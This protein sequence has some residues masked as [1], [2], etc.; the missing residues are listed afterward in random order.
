M[1]SGYIDAFGKIDTPFYFY[2]MDLFRT[3]VSE[4]ASLSSQYGIK[5]HYAI[6]ANTEERLLRHIASY[7]FGADCVSG[8]EVL[9][10][11]RCGFRP[12]DIVFAGVGKSDREITESLKLGIGTFN[13]ESLQEIEV[14][15]GFAASLGVRA[16]VS[17]RINP[18]ID[19]HTHKYVTTGLYENKFG[20]SRHE[21]EAL[22]ALLGRCGAVDLQGLHFHIGSQITDVEEVY[23]L[24]CRR[25]SEIVR[26]FEDKGF[27]IRNIDLGGGP[28]RDPHF[29]CAFRQERGDEDLPD[30]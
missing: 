15:N 13:C 2:D 9:H 18:D 16:N 8:N 25:A 22:V 10:A 5:V 4:L 11:Y 14:V 20:V 23:S 30:P 21:F 26:W 27:E 24:E 29:P 19:A 7:G 12:E 3:T 28:V 1:Q 6:K 17:V